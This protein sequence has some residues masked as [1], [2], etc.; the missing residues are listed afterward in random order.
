MDINFHNRFQGESFEYCFNNDTQLG[1][2]KIKSDRECYVFE[3]KRKSFR[4]ISNS[5]RDSYRD[6]YLDNAIFNRLKFN[7][8]KVFLTGKAIYN[9]FHNMLNIMSS[10][11]YHS[12]DRV[13]IYLYYNFTYP[14][15][16]HFFVILL[17][18][19]FYWSPTS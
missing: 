16:W 10:N 15:W 4:K 1:W 17:A 6:S 9:L 11:R 13:Y 14:S 5:Y 12:F 7:S 18:N 8:S 3:T 19:N 2:I